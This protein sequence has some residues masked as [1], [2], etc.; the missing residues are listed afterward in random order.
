MSSE[1][2]DDYLEARQEVVQKQQSVTQNGHS[3]H[4]A[5]PPLLSNR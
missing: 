1:S 4:K 2:S 5:R 3:D